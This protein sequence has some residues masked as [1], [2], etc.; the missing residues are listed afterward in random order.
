MAWARVD[1]LHRNS[2]EYLWVFPVSRGAE[3][4]HV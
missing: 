2:G 1:R 4:C 3:L